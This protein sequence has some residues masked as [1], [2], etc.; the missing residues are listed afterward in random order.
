MQQ[1]VLKALHTP[2]ESL[3]PAQG[4]DALTNSEEQTGSGDRAAT[5]L[6]HPAGTRKPGK[7]LMEELQRLKA[8]TAAPDGSPLSKVPL[9]FH[10]PVKLTSSSSWH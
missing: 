2:D 5:L 7:A 1:V 8:V 6:A 3:L 9:H 4:N 10:H